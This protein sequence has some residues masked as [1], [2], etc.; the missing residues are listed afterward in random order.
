MPQT[1]LLSMPIQEHKLLKDWTLALHKGP[2]SPSQCLSSLPARQLPTTWHLHITKPPSA[3]YSKALHH[4]DC[5][6]FSS[7]TSVCETHTQE[8]L[9]SRKGN[10]WPQALHKNNSHIQRNRSPGAVATT[11]VEHPEMNRSVRTFNNQV[12]DVAKLSSKI[13]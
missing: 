9:P 10:Q 7:C 13:Q 5:S 1:L 3:S 11:H 6:F 4:E 8:N 12:K 2:L